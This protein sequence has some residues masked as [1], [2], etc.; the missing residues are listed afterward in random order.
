MVVIAVRAKYVPPASVQSS[1]PTGPVA[2]VKSISRLMAASSR[3]AS[4]ALRF[5]VMVDTIS[6]Y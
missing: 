6:T 5:A 3:A 4:L 1:C 2:N